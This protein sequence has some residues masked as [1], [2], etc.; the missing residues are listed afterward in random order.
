VLLHCLLIQV[1]T[2]VQETVG[3]TPQAGI[4]LTWASLDIR[5][6][7]GQRVALMTR[8]V[9][10]RV[11]GMPWG[12]AALGFAALVALT[13]VAPLIATRLKPLTPVPMP[14]P[15]A[16]LLQRLGLMHRTPIPASRVRVA[17]DWVPFVRF[18]GID[19]LESP[20]AGGRAPR[21]RDLGPVFATVR[22]KLDGNV[23]TPSYH[24]KNG[25]AAFLAA[26]T[27]VYTVHGYKPIFRLAAYELGHLALFE[28]DANLRARRGADLL[29]LAGKV[30]FIGINSPQDG[31]TQ[32]AAITSRA[33]VA[34][35]VAQVLNARAVSGL[36]NPSG[37]QYFIAF[38]LCDGTAVTRSYWTGSGD[39]APGIRV[40]QSFQRAITQAV[41]A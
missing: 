7:Q 27:P 3:Q 22:F 6:D 31:T 32:I 37:R 38:H 13:F 20:P 34:T 28:A 2:V 10:K 19:Y 30:R 36:S 29:D 1:Y 25:D 15:M 33:Q 11:H 9:G 24:A 8:R 40:P 4:R 26:G 23:Q 12:R 35:L 17:I 39:L 21:Q 41:R 5:T 16:A 14:A 18:N